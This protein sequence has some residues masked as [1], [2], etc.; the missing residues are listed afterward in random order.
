MNINT[1]R[2]KYKDIIMHG[3]KL[4][5]YLEFEKD[6]LSSDES[7]Y[8][9]F[10]FEIMGNRK[11]ENLYKYI[12][13]CFKNRQN[14]EKVIDFLINKYQQGIDDAILKADLIQILGNLRSK[15]VKDIISL[16]MNSSIRDLRYRCIIVLGWLGSTLNDLKLLNECMT[17]DEDAEL[18]GYSATAMRQIWHNNKTTKNNIT[19]YIKKAIIIEN[20]EKAL[21]G[22]IITIQ[23]LYKKKLG[24]K[25]S[26]YGD[27][28]GN[29]IEAKLKTIKL[30]NN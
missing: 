24:L 9:E 22:M 17:T 19:E 25:E 14:K 29:V 30:L 11:K 8:L 1:V 18:R 21:I 13:A 10:H 12:R 23:D 27:I 2:A 28:S 26:Q 3:A 20:N 5:Q 6:L 7:E 16:E 4:E 15:K